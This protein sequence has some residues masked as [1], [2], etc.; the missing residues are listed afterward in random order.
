VGPFSSVVDVVDGVVLEVVVVEV[1]V[2]VVVGVVEDVVVEGVVV[3]T[4]VV[5]VGIDVVLDVDVVVVVDAVLVVVV[6]VGVVV[7]RVEVF[8]LSRST[9][10]EFISPPSVLSGFLISFE[11]LD[12]SSQS[13]IELLLLSLP[14]PLRLRFLPLFRLASVSTSNR[15]LMVQSTRSSTKT[16]FISRNLNENYKLLTV[17]TSCSLV[18]ELKIDRYL[19]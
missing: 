19:R 7:L 6:V 16:L 14:L 13:S 9:S 5:V 15:L 8:F 11:S 10:F 1:V 3:D 12:S 4:V 17:Y 18:N 2:D